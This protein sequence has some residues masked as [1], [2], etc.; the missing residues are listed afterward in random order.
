MAP[1]MVIAASFAGIA[2]FFNRLNIPG[3]SNLLRGATA[4]P[5]V[6]D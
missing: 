5:C 4:N 1:T 3:F 6:I 2:P